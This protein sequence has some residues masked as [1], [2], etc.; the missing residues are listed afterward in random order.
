MNKKI[1]VTYEPGGDERAVYHEIF[2]NLAQV[3]FLPVE[4]AHDRR[5]LLSEA[6]IIT[7]LS[8]SAKELAAAEIKLLERVGFIQLI[9]AG[10]DNVP[11]E[12]IPPEIVLAS[13]VGAFARPIAEHV[14]ALTLALAKKIVPKNDQLRQG[15]FDRSGY[16]Q[17]LRGAVCGIIGFGGNGRE[18][19]R[20]MRAMGMQIYG[21]NRSGQTDF[22]VDFIGSI[23]DIP[24][25]LQ[26][27]R[28][29]VVTTPLT[30]ATKDLI[31]P[32]ELNWMKKDAIL[33]NVGRG[34][35]INQQALYE[36][37][38]AW[39][40]FFAGIDTWWNEPVG[41]TDFELKYPFFELP[42]ILGSP[43][44]A[45]HVPGSIPYATRRALEN[46]RNFLVGD[47]LRGVQ[48]REDYLV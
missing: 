18:I 41:S 6:E 46:V 12:L 2:D 43:H 3:R 5:R 21:I 11:F 1:V 24:T 44:S 36:H 10:A 28:V 40:G 27:S 17:E 20:T 37:L 45:D 30:R 23:K 39:P 26:A 48:N 22:P 32:K 42:N 19:A 4:S 25:V 7:A 38:K 16:N 9:Y 47:E 8:F 15:I 33:I 35:V 13:N 14:L 31:G 29:V 34:D